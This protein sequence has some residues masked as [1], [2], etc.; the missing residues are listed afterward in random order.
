M[1][2]QQNLTSNPKGPLDDEV[3][4]KFSKTVENTKS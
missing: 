3:I 1:T 2:I 4:K